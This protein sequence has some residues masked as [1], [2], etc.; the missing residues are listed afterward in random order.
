[1]IVYIADHR[2][3]VLKYTTTI[4]NESTRE[5]KFEIRKLYDI[6]AMEYRF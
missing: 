1:M 5:I 2:T 4:T 3:S 6:F